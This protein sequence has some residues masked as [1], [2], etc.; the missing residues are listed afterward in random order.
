MGRN[1]RGAKGEGKMSRGLVL[2]GALSACAF[3]VMTAGSALAATT[4]GQTGAPS[5]S[6]SYSGSQ[7]LVMA[8]DV[9]S[10]AGLVTSLNTQA[11]SCS[12]ASGTYNLQ[13]LR[14]EGTDSYGNPQ[15]LVLGDTGNQADP[16]DSQL[17]SYPVNV[18]VHA[19]DVIGAYAVTRWQSVLAIGTGTDNFL[20]SD[21]E[22]AV[23][24]TIST[25]HTSSDTV[26]ESATLLLMPITKGQ[27]MSGGWQ[28]YGITFKNQGDC[29]RFIATGGKH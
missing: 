19:G 3:G 2:V 22:P 26:D 7:E 10:S 9:M 16:C 23:G 18:P 14:P 5:N 12:I 21:S 20:L 1:T 28:N 8:S 17:H 24:D 15:Y 11:S 29:V 27:C 6:F 4:V 13:V 25:P